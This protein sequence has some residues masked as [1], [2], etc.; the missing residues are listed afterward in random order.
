MTEQTYTLDEAKR[1]LTL[2]RC[3]ENGHAWAVGPQRMCEAY[4]SFIVCQRCGE[5]APVSGSPESGGQIDRL[6][7]EVDRLRGDRLIITWDAAEAQVDAEHAYLCMEERMGAVSAQLTD[8]LQRL[9][10][11][12]ALADQWDEDSDPH[13]HTLRAV[14]DGRS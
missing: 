10:A 13:S 14:L 6:R 11:V 1:E 5:T 8:A 12:E 4:P 9:A 2:R 3:R 7:A